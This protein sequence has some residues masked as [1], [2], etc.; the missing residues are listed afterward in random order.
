MNLPSIY[1]STFKATTWYWC[2]IGGGKRSCHSWIWI[3][4]INGT[5]LDISHSNYIALV[6]RQQSSKYHQIINR[7]NLETVVWINLILELL[8]D[9]IL[10]CV[11]PKN[12]K[13]G[14]CRKPIY[15]RW[16]RL[17]KDKYIQIL[18]LSLN[19]WKFIILEDFYRAKNCIS[20][21]SRENFPTRKICYNFVIQF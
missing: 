20:S 11:S 5:I 1:S 21:N 14:L 12:I 9:F 18:L 15:I 10:E 4:Y 13:I 3:S 7:I 17:E 19:L 8:L 6:Y 2:F 16:K